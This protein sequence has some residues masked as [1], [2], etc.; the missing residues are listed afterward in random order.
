MLARQCSVIKL[1]M[2]PLELSYMLPRASHVLLKTPSSD[3]AHSM[4]QHVPPY[5]GGA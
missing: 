2:L 1:E 5:G 4:P 3:V